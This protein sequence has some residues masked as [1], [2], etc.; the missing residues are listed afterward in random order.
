MS[1]RNVISMALTS[2][3][4]A[5]NLSCTNKSTTSAPAKEVNLAIWGNYLG[6][7]I[8]EKF[9]KETGIKINISNYSSNEELLAKVQSGASG[10]DVAVP[11]DYMVEIMAKSNM[12]ETLNHEKL[13]N[14]SNI[15]PNFLGLNFD[16]ANTYSV[17]YAWSTAGLAVYKDLVKGTIKSWKQVFENKELSGKI[18]M[19][20][21]VREVTAAALKVNGFSVN[22]VNPAEL[23]KA[24]K[25]LMAVKPRI[26]MFRTDTIDALV[27]KEI[28][29]AHAYSSDALQAVEKSGGKIEYVIP[30]E[31]GTRA[32]DNMVILKGA[33]NA[34]NAHALI[35]FMLKP[36]S[37]LS[38]VKATMAGPVLKTT[39]EQLPENLRNN[40]SLF[41]SASTLSHLEALKDVGE[42]TKLYDDLWTQV[43]TN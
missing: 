26:K 7:D 10:I 1:R 35:N 13:P 41:P 30:E 38:L 5:F 17:P 23:E 43:K 39:R 8:Q 4:I 2:L 21:D 16:K 33:K 18:S 12:L 27:E 14:K 42:Q 6:P 24:K 31:G 32:V 37:N 22:T 25:T 20:D 9:T 40:P 36:E 15:D 28:A 3:A 11:S 34:D 29:V 19:L